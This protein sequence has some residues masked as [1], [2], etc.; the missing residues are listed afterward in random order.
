[1]A[2]EGYKHLSIQ[3]KMQSAIIRTPLNSLSSSGLVSA[4]LPGDSVTNGRECLFRFKTSRSNVL[5]TKQP[6]IVTGKRG[7]I[8]KTSWYHK[9]SN[10]SFSPHHLQKEREKKEMRTA[11]IKLQSLWTLVLILFFWRQMIQ[12]E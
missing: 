4:G 9:N 5:V 10:I 12:W 6:T 7:G 8:N 2:E 3:K 1:L 11:V